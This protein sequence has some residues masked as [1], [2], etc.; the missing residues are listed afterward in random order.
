MQHFLRT[1]APARPSANGIVMNTDHESYI[2]VLVRSNVDRSRW[3]AAYLLKVDDHVAA[4]VTCWDLQ[5][6]KVF[7]TLDHPKYGQIYVDEYRR[8]WPVFFR[9]VDN[10]LGQRYGD[11]ALAEFID[12][13]E[14]NRKWFV[15]VQFRGAGSQSDAK[16]RVAVDQAVELSASISQEFQRQLSFA[17]KARIGLKGGNIGYREG[18]AFADKWGKRLDWLRPFVG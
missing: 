12:P 18:K 2:E 7:Q 8:I 16:A 15:A 13:D 11:G 14:R 1:A 5:F 4:A 10:T 3:F 6:D 17:Q 9:L